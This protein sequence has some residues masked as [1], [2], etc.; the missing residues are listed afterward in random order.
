MKK[1][2]IEKSTSGGKTKLK[3]DDIETSVDANVERFVIE[4]P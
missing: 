1:L 4:W 2:W 3:L